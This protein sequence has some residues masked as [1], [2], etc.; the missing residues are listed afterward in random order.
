MPLKNLDLQYNRALV[1]AR[2][3]LMRWMQRSF[4]FFVALLLAG[5]AFFGL[6]QPVKGQIPGADQISMFQSMTPDQQDEIMRQLGG[7][8]L[9]GLGG[10]GNY[11]SFQSGGYDRGAPIDR[12]RPQ[13]YGP[14]NDNYQTYPAYP[15]D[16]DGNPQPLIPV[17]KGLDTVI[18]EIDFHLPPRAPGQSL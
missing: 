5:A 11:G 3:L 14:G 2:R 8:G 10:L 9:S 6:V 16:E 17:L 4:A 18:I 12:N 15:T 7:G 1:W 13:G